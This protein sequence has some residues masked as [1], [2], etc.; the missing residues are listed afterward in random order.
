MDADDLVIRNRLIEKARFLAQILAESEIELDEK[1]L[2]AFFEANK[3]DYY[4][5][6]RV[7]FSHVYF[8]A[9]KRGV[10]AAQTA[11][12]VTLKQLNAGAAPLSAAPKYGDRFSYRANFVAR[13]QD[14]VASHFGQPIAQ[15]IFPLSGDGRWHGPY[16][17]PHG[18]HLV[19][20]VKVEPGRTPPLEEIRAR[21]EQEARSAQVRAKTEAT[22]K[23]IVDAYEVQVDYEP[24][25]GAAVALEG[26]TG[27]LIR[28]ESSNAS[29][30]SPDPM[31]TV[32]SPS[33]P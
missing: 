6:P 11:A 13:T 2:Q 25:T 22:I 10:E 4:I 21:V 26:H 24:E 3:A 20:V 19:S 33:F 32:Q 18:A 12:A 15:T 1:A 9:E 30:N 17:S 23:E 5:E 28:A 14:F 31:G 7:T 8:D 29:L 27:F 16:R